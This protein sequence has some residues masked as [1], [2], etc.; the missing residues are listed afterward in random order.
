M[1]LLELDNVYCQRGSEIKHE[2]EEIVIVFQINI[3]PNVL[4]HSA[5]SMGDNI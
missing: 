1:H 3:S 5:I 4:S 2:E